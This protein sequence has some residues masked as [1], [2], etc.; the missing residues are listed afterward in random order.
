MNKNAKF[1]SARLSYRGI[2]EMDLNQLSVWLSTQEVTRYFR[3]SRSISYAEELRWYKQSYCHDLKR[4]DF[5]VFVKESCQAIGRVGV[6][7]L[8]LDSSSCEISYMIAEP[9]YRR[10]GYAAEAIS[11]IMKK[12]M[13]QDIHH[14]FAEVHL[15]NIPS[16]RLIEK[17]GFTCYDEHPPFIIYHG[18]GKRDELS[19]LCTC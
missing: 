14:F 8:D 17:L 18:Q 2:N 1:M 12:M 15:Q 3:Q 16:R 10:Q 7:K 6:N 19:D 13:R 4:Y 9:S 5:M 11:T